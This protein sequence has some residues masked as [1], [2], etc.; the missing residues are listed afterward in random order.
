[1]EFR[2]QL[3]VVCFLLLG[4]SYHSS[5]V[6]H[7]VYFLSVWWHKAVSFSHCG[8]RLLTRDWGQPHPQGYVLMVILILC[9]VSVLCLVFSYILILLT[10][11]SKYCDTVTFDCLLFVSSLPFFFRTFAHSF[12][13]IFFFLSFFLLLCCSFQWHITVVR[14]QII[15]Q[16]RY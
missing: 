4:N 7:C 3:H 1:M 11:V 16:K 14:Y 6:F 12:A 15:F 9:S 5:L 13:L 10:F 2:G 8:L